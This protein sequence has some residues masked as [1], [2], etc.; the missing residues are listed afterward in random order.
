MITRLREAHLLWP[1]VLT[2]LGLA[3]LFALGNWQMRRLAWKEAL[4]AKVEARAKAAPVSLEAALGT[5]TGS[6]MEDTAEAIEFTRV[7]L[8]GRFHHDREFH[9]WSPGKAG[10][11]WSVVTPL[12]LSPPL[13]T[14]DTR[15]FNTVL[16]I[17]GSVPDAKKVTALRT[18]GNPDGEV[19]FVGR[20][21]L[22]HV[23]AFSS[24]EN[25]AKNEWYE[26]DL[27]SMRKVLA[28]KSAQVPAA[29]T[30]PHASARLVPFYIEAETATGG[31]QGPQ[32]QLNKVNLINRHLE[33]A[34]TWYGLAI[35]L[36]GVYLVF[37][38]GRLRQR[39]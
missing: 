12:T 15:S 17:R 23:G 11:S 28:M 36:L 19:E 26:L 33:Y 32:P 10:P 1:T 13:G 37:A 16:V 22:S 18:A 35:T 30:P 6:Q 4:I 14:P 24:V 38:F 27:A 31:P 39:G 3:I 2:L 25:V 29:G 9:V 7:S 34:L 5:Y 8:T 21:R 20:V